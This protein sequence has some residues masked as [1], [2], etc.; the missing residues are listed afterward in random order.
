M[1]RLISPLLDCGQLVNKLLV[2]DVINTTNIREA[3]FKSEKVCIVV[4]IIDN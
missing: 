3:C 1:H 4:V 2:Y